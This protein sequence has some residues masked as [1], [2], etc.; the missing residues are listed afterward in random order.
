MALYRK[1][2]PQKLDDLVGQPQVTD[3]LS[4]SLK[5]GIFSHAYLFSGPRGTGKTSAA[6]ILAH[7][8]NGIPYSEALNLDIIEIDAASNRRIEDIRDLR[9]VVKLAPTKLKFKV[10]IID[11]VHMLTNE[12]FNAL[13]KT[14]EEPPEHAI[15]IL[16][17]TDLHKVPPTILS[18]T[19][20]FTFK[21]LPNKEL[22]D[23]LAKIAKLE[24]IDIDGSA[25]SLV[26]DLG[27]GS[28]RDALSILDQ[29]GSLS[30]KITEDVVRDI[31]G[32]PARQAEDEIMEALNNYDSARLLSLSGRLIESGANQKEIIKNLI[33]DLVKIAKPT[34]LHLNLIDD[35]AAALGSYDPALFLQ[36]A[37]LKFNPN[38][39]QVKLSEPKVVQPEITANTK[40]KPEPETKPTPDISKEVEENE[41]ESKKDDKAEDEE[42]ESG[43]EAGQDIS[44]PVEQLKFSG[45]T[46]QK[47]L[48]E[49]KNSSSATYAM[50]RLSNAEPEGDTLNIT[51]KFEFHKKKMNEGKNTRVLLDALS[52][53]LGTEP[54]YKF[55]VDKDVK[56]K[57]SSLNDQPQ[58]ALDEGEVDPAQ[59][60]ILSKVSDIMGGGEVLESE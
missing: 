59:S 27:G 49:V 56:I 33:N 53:V 13:L 9:E 12:S 17:T 44:K 35:L 7:E 28:V 58:E 60:S 14:L 32:M 3:I 55:L 20:K 51:F 21:L 2:R 41:L 11:E 37:L 19:Q 15:F 6:R 50:L 42:V 26:A 54:Q 25:L 4:L 46:W 40:L 1:Y 34:N 10:Y 16:A 47:I 39:E 31:M 38:I 22:A 43:Q 8:F 45:V 36:I 30:K 52:L 23:H 5:K 24:K 29:L 48:E 18:R 57:A